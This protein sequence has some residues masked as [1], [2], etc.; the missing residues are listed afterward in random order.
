MTTSGDAATPTGGWLDDQERAAW[1]G[2]AALLFRL[3]TALDNQL[4]RD[5]G[6]TLFEYIVMARLSEQPSHRV[7]MS[8]LAVLANGSR[9]R[10]SHTVRRLAAKGYMRKEVDPDDGR[11]TD[12]ILTETGYQLVI[13]AAPAHVETVRRLLV[14]AVTREQLG[15][16]ADVGN[17]VLSR[18]DPA[19]SW[20]P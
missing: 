5:A 2:V 16:L 6:V 1:L 11:Y 17:R 4:E 10:L 19:A 3:P 20:P 18:I 13:R 8:D 14:G 7:H 9:S 15:H 12:A